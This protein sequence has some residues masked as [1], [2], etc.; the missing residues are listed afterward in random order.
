[1][2]TAPPGDEGEV[3]MYDALAV[4]LPL[5][6]ATDPDGGAESWAAAR[7]SI[8]AAYPAEANGLLAAARTG[9]GAVEEALGEL[10][11]EPLRAVSPDHEDVAE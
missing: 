2:T 4:L 11:A 7:A 1:L 5:Q 6:I 3:E 9:A 10:L 8:A